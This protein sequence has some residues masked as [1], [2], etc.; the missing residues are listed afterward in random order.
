MAVSGRLPAVVAHADWSLDARKRRVAR[1][2]HEGAGR[3]R[4]LAPAPVG[5]LRIF[6][7][8]L[9][10]G[11]PW[12]GPLLLGVDFP[13][14][15][16]RAYARRAGVTDFRRLLPQLGGGPWRDFFRVAEGPLEVDVTRPFY[17]LRPGRRGTVARRHLVEGLG[18]AVQRDLLRV[19]DLANGHRRDACAMFWTLGPQQVGKAAI[20]GWRDFLIPALE[21]GHDLALW[22]F[23]GALESLL[24]ER[25]IVV[26][27]VYPAEI[28]GQLDLPAARGKRRQQARAKR[29]PALA[30]HLR[31]LGITADPTF[32]GALA[33][34]F[35]AAADAEDCFDAVVG[36]IGMLNVVLGERPAG[37]PG[38]E[39][40]RI[41]GWNL[42]QEVA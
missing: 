10:R 20:V 13:I 41:E 1:A 8:R 19:C 40:R 30:A 6:L 2:V 28:Y 34:G 37:L 7:D 3:Y 38:E 32:R 23:E 17:P 36:L 22:P 16:P 39:I 42:G 12:T 15:L 26:A 4:A 35:G 21:A 11:V 25:D 5:D 9:R 14:G 33:D 18:L 24:A 29:A 27:E 31:H